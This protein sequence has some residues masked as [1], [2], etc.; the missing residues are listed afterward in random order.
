MG[1]GQTNQMYLGVPTEASNCELGTGNR[2]G[3][4]QLKQRDATY[5]SIRDEMK[6][7]FRQRT[8][9]SQCWPGWGPGWHHSSAAATLRTCC[10]LLLRVVR[11]VRGGREGE[12]GRGSM[13]PWWLLAASW[14]TQY[15]NNLLPCKRTSSADSTVAALLPLLLTPPLSRSPCSLNPIKGQ[16]FVYTLSFKLSSNVDNNPVGPKTVPCMHLW[17][18]TVAA[19][20]TR[21][22]TQRE[23]DCL[24]CLCGHH[25]LLYHVRSR[26][27][28]VHY[29]RSKHKYP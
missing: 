15:L 3:N 16:L 6:F 13:R 25:Y 26:K 17:L 20:S 7:A 24:P 27:L 8:W 18:Q 21:T 22:H 12:G 5:A 29:I 28:W 2:Q 9:Q 23:R 1:A 19:K 4:R 11:V 14:K 10:L